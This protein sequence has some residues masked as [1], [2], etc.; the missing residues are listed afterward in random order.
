MT[1][2]SLFLATILGYMVS[3]KWWTIS[4]DNDKSK[5]NNNNNDPFCHESVVHQL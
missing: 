2:R 1:Q 4:H 3:V 5:S